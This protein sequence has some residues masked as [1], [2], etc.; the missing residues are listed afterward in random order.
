[1]GKVTKNLSWLRRMSGSPVSSQSALTR[2]LLALRF[3]F[4]DLK[5]CLKD[6]YILLPIAEA[7]IVSKKVVNH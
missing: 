5:C 4:Q 7:F 2:L 6:G 1:M 3:R